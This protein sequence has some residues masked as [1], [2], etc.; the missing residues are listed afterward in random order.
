MRLL[1]EWSHPDGQSL[2]G[3]ESESH[4]A[5][6]PGG[7]VARFM[8]LFHEYPHASGDR[9]CQA[10][11]DAMK[12]TPH[13]PN[14]LSLTSGALTALRRSGFSRRSFLQGTGALIVS[15]SMGGL[16]TALDAQ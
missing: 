11:N 15:F 4:S 5:R 3:Q 12:T 1:P 2:P 9:A 13:T 10:G 16:L 14:E 6:N 8:P 7:N